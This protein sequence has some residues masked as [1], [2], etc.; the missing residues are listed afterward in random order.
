MDI[1]SATPHTL[2]PLPYHGMPGYPYAPPAAYPMTPERLAVWERY[3]T[4]L[5]RAP[6][7]RLEAAPPGGSP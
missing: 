1:N 7:A 2:E 4:R 6:V 3:N 5:V